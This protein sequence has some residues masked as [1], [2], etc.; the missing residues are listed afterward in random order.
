M[1]TDT[2]T[3]VATGAETLVLHKKPVSLS[4]TG[5]G[6]ATV[7]L[8]RQTGAGTWVIAKSMNV[9]TEETILAG[10]KGQRYR[11]R[12]SAYTSGT[13]VCELGG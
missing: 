6:V 9:D 12:C 2:F 10:T 8:E 4:A 3:G 1:I 11:F 5:F 13:I 7:L